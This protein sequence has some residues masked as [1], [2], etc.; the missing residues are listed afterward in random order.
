[1]RARVLFKIGVFG[2][3]VCGRTGDGEAVGEGYRY[4]PLVYVRNDISSAYVYDGTKYPFCIRAE[5]S[6]T[7]TPSH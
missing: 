6:Y 3:G 7:P 4:T 5:R 1:V 2:D